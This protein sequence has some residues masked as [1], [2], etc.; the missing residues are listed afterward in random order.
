MFNA[1]HLK[2]LEMLQR[3]RVF[4]GTQRLP[5]LVRAEDR[6]YYVTKVQ[7]TPQDYTVVREWLGAHLLKVWGL[8]VPDFAV[9]QVQAHHV[10]V[11]FHPRLTA[12]EFSRP[13]FD[14]HPSNP[15]LLS[16]LPERS[17][18]LHQRTQACAIAPPR[19]GAF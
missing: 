8:P 4:A 14:K 11:G 13:A 10:P 15:V 6:K 16:P 19:S 5:V 3:N 1:P 12:Y 9:V 17:F 7:R 2:S 18:A